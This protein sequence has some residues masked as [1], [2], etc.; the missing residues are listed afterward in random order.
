M[1]AKKKYI[2]F[3]NQHA[4]IIPVFLRAIWLD[5]VAEKWNVILQEEDNEIKAALP[6]CTKGNILTNRIYL[7][8]VSF[9]Q[10]IIFLQHYTAKQQQAISEN[11]FRQLP[12]TLKSYFKFLPEYSNID[13]HA[14]KYKSEVYPTYC[15]KKKSEISLSTNHARNVQKGVKNQYIISES[16]NISISYALLA[17]TFIRQ[18]LQIKLSFELYKKL[19]HITQKNG[20]GKTLDCIDQRNNVLASILIVEDAKCV[21]YLYGGY[22][23]SYKNSG[24]MTF[25]LHYIIQD[26]IQRH[27]IFNFCGSSKKSIANFFEGFGAKKTSIPI[28]KKSIY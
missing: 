5:A 15:I 1:T 10:S 24:A 4:D 26:T 8:D 9:Y 14:L 28:W 16:K 25:L 18:N 21:Y 19:Q 6:Y 27:K 7:P 2:A 3:C 17:S 13:L 11:L 12:H 20:M 23:T 22:D